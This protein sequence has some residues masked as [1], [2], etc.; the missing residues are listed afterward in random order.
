MR[1]SNG[2]RDSRN[3]ASTEGHRRRPSSGTDAPMGRAEP[4]AI[5]WLPRPGLGYRVAKR[6]LD[7]TFSLFA[8]LALAPLFLLISLAIKLTSQGPIFFRQIRV[9]YRGRLF[10]Y[11]RFRTMYVDSAERA[12]EDYVRELMAYESGLK[13]GRAPRPM[14]RDPRVTS[15]GRLMR[16]TALDEL[17]QFINVLRGDMTLVGPRPPIQYEVTFYD[18]WHW[19]RLSCKPGVTGLWQIMPA[20]SDT[21]DDMVRLDLEYAKRPSLWSDLRIL[22]KTPIAFMRGSGPY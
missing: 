13:E 12:H 21:F 10:D 16:A 20:T 9:G 1:V 11:L 18:E 19:L 15:L 3:E 4:R 5:S 7:V 17:P 8:L 22:F 2:R 14:P 6:L